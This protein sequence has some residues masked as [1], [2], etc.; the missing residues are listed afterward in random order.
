MCVVPN[1]VGHKNLTKMFKAYVMLDNCSQG[2]FIRDELIEVLG[3]TGQKLQLSLTAEKSGDTMAIEGLIVSGI[4]LIKTSTSEQIE[5]SR[6]YSKQSLPAEGEEIA[7]PNK[8]N[9]SDYF[10]SINRETVQQDDI[11][12][13]MLIGANYIKELESLG[14]ISSRNDGPYA[15]RTKLGW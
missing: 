5:L 12:I 3:I 4:N 10:R 2:T 1:W 9:Q 13:G 14:I 7:T 8:I 6:A 15:Y 11:E